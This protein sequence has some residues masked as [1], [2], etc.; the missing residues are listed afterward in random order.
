VVAFTTI[1][2]GLRP[3]NDLA[4]SPNDFGSVHSREGGGARVVT[5]D[6]HD[7]KFTILDSMVLIA[8]TAFGLLPVG[9]E[10]ERL[11]SRMSQVSW[12]RLRDESYREFLLHQSP[13]VRQIASQLSGVVVFF[14]MFY[15]VVLFGMRLLPPRPP[16]RN[17]SRQPGVWACGTATLAL[18]LVVWVPFFKP[19][20]I[21]IAVCVAWL[22]LA[23]SG[24]WHSESSW[25]DQAGRF[26]GFC[27]VAILPPFLWFA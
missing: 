27:W 21:P 25:L 26:L 20:T 6:S 14:L 17:L 15:T 10:I 24:G 23:A 7:R 3:T 12:G 4:D 11:V 5:T 19:V 2:G 9:S 8:A 13:L 18:V 16:L 1:R 22:V